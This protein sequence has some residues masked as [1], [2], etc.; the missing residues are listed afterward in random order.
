MHGEEL[1]RIESE[2]VGKVFALT[3]PRRS[4]SIADNFRFFAGGARFMQGRPT[5]EYM[6]GYTSMIRR[7]PIGWP[8]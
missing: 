8:A 1:G 5:G 7:E 3:C 2:N 4:R 6:E